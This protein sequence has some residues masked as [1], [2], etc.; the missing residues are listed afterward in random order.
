MNLKRT[1][2]DNNQVCQINQKIINYDFHVNFS[3]TVCEYL[4]DF[5]DRMEGTEEGMALAIKPPKC[6]SDGSFMAMQ[7]QLKRMRVTK[8]E[9][10]KV[11]EQNN[12]RQMRKLLQN[13]RKRRDIETLK[14]V[15]VDNYQQQSRR[16]DE[17]GVDTQS[18]IDFLKR[19]IFESPEKFIT[20]LFG[21]EPLQGRT[22]RV[23]DIQA[24]DYDDDHYDE[25]DARDDRKLALKSQNRYQNE[26]VEVEVEQCYCVDRFGTEIP[27][28]KG[29]MNVS[30]E[31]CG[32]LRNS[33]D[34]LDLTCR[35]GCDY[36]FVIDPETQ[37]P[38]CQCRDS[39]DG[40]QC[41]DS[42]ECRTVEV[43]CEDSYCPSV[44]VCFPKKQGQCPFLVPPAGEEDS[45]DACAFECRSDSHCFGN[46]KC[47]SNGCGTVCVEPMLKSACQHL[48][49]IQI[50]Q[51][52]ELGIPAKQKYIAQCNDDGSWKTIQCGPNNVCW[53]VDER[54]NEKSGTRTSDGVPN[55]TARKAT[56]CPKVKCRPCEHG[57]VFDENGCKT[58]SCKDLCKE[59]KCPL[60]EQCE[61]VQVECIN[62]NNNTQPCPRMPICTPIRDSICTEGLPLKQGGREIN[63]G[64][65][66]VE[67]PTTHSCNL[68]PIT[69]RGVC[70][71]KSR[72]V[73]FESIDSSCILN[74][75]D[76]TDSVVKYRFNPRYNKCTP[77]KLA[78]GRLSSSCASK[79]LFHSEQACKS[80]C[81]VLTQCERLRL[82]NSIAARRRAD[83]TDIWFRPRCDPENGSWSSVQCIGE[84]TNDNTRVCWCSD[85]KGSP[86]KGSLTKGIEP[87][88]NYRQARRRVQEQVD[89]VMEELIKQITFITD[90]S[91]FIDDD[92]DTISKIKSFKS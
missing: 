82:K 27:R 57:F 3:F 75:N 80:V 81:P 41:E 68:N 71:A 24:E 44:P 61:L 2:R 38:T 39:C 15:R 32:I 88:C 84:N 59:I 31:T 19:K 54:G 9:Q 29:S 40:I 69:K 20:E 56:H 11:L 87:V 46:K 58:C 67:C 72:D 90:E 16:S 10:K 49:S 34:C 43:S 23:I 14:L 63:C 62:S 13:S 33:I 36:G 86:I 17:G 60:D 4:R 76:V 65:D 52:I 55:C 45:E 7:C 66:A 78:K 74:E 83:K 6:N 30:E 21:A 89:P 8:A 77:V 85:K 28:T 53:C 47:C 73:C 42:Q 79:N 48:Q 18:V 5:S 50:H 25:I 70:C 22:A 12:I 1:P 91:N 26:L 51:A 64:P 35:M 37:C 92:L